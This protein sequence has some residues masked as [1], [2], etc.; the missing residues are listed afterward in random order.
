MKTNDWIKGSILIKN[1]K[2][3][4]VNT[5]LRHLQ[6]FVNSLAENKHI[7]EQK[8]FKKKYY[9]KYT[10]EQKD[11]YTHVELDLIV[12]FIEN[13]IYKNKKI[14]A[15][16]FKFLFFSGARITEALNI[17]KTDILEDKIKMSNKITKKIEYIYFTITCLCRLQ[18]S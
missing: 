4:S 11:Y 17:K 12:N 14:L 7:E 13:S 9:Q 2:P 6:V 8:N 10:E 1:L 15:L 18:A 5:Y 16:F 3:V